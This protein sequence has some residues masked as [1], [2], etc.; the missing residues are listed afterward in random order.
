MNEPTLTT[1]QVWHFYCQDVPDC[2][3]YYLLLR[4]L[5]AFAMAT[6]GTTLAALWEA[7]DLT[8]G[9]LVWIRPCIAGE[10]ELMP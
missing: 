4:C 3:D 1:G 9:D 8:K 2:D 5:P 6:D 7:F 10:W